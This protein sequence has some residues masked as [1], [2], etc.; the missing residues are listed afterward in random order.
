MDASHRGHPT[1]VHR[2]HSGRRGRP[3][4]IFDPAF[5]AWAYNRRSISALARFLN[6][7]R[8]TL[9]NALIAHG[10]IPQ[11]LP[12][13]AQLED[14]SLPLTPRSIDTPTLS[15]TP[16]ELLEP[17]DVAAPAFLPQDVQQ[18]AIE[19]SST[20]SL[21]NPTSRHHASISDEDLDDLII[22]LR[23]HFR[24]AGIA[25]LDGMLTR[26]GYRVQRERIRESLLRIDPVRRVFE[27]IRIRRRQ[28]SVAGPN[29]LW[30]HDGQ[31]GLIRWGIVIHGFIDGY[32]RLITGLRASNNNYGETVLELFLSAAAVY[33]VPSRL[34]G[35]HGVENILVAAWMED[36]RGGHRG[37]YIWAYKFMAQIGA[38][39]ANLFVILEIRHGLDINNWRH[40]WLLQHL[41]LPLINFD[42]LFFAEAWNEHRIQ[43]RDGPN[44][45]P[46]DMFGFDMLVHGV[47]G[48]PLEEMM[49]SEELEVYGIDWEGLRED[50]LLE[51]QQLNNGIDEG[52]TSWIGQTG[53]PEHLNEVRVDSPDN[54]FTQEDIDWL[55]ATVATWRNSADDAG[56][57]E[58]WAHALAAAQSISNAF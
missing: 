25:M 1:V 20:S 34:R 39:W 37:S 27:R 58:L 38:T 3:Q 12:Q 7:G 53:P 19:I 55:E 14:Y 42:L 23:F 45:S 35:D 6:V 51:S 52:N 54:P 18:I 16:D 28:Y 30:H 10:I 17:D 50:R 29:S 31:H 56:R 15:T 32:S 13:Q 49:S 40:I 2:L 57:I 36:R 9:R 5:L 11:A 8:T 44:R 46:S 24:R 41:F 26:L 22:R 43:I 4:V 21:R 33:G 48:D 47:R